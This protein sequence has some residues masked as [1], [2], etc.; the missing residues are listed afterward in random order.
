MSRNT[1]TLASVLAA[2][3]EARL[4]DVHVALPAQVESF[5]A[6]RRCVTVQPLIRQA[7]TDTESGERSV[8][9]L[10]VINDV[11]IVFPGSGAFCV[12]WP[13]AKG[14]T[15]L[16]VFSEASID[17]WLTR[18]GDVDPLDDRRFNLSDAI[19]IPGLRSLNAPPSGS[20]APAGTMILRT[21]GQIHAGGDQALALHAKLSALRDHVNGLM[22]NGSGSS[23][24]GAAPSMGSGTSVLKGG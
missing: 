22:V 12:E 2:A 5:D 7:T 15:G 16:L 21:A 23:V 14:D 20:P 4:A 10:P 11:P 9:R 19:F 18:G 8:E 3:L 17:K 24:N 6:D 13:V 1:P